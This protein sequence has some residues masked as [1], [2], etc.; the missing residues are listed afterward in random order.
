MGGSWLAM[1]FFICF[2]V[3]SVGLLWFRIFRPMLEDFGVLRPADGVNSYSVDYDERPASRPSEASAPVASVRQFEPAELVLFVPPVQLLNSPHVTSEDVARLDTIARL[4]AAGTVTESAALVAVYDG[5]AGVAKVS[6]GGSAAYTA[7]RDALR[8]L[9]VA[10]GWK[11]APPP[12]P[13]PEPRLVPIS[14]GREGH[15]EL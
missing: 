14:G 10:Y 8:A 3:I 1:I 7:K 12:E 5:R 6:K 11:P 15:F 2:G 4:M 13:P 9:A